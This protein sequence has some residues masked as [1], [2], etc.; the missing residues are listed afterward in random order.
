MVGAAVQSYELGGV[1][2][3]SRSARH[4]LVL[5]VVSSLIMGSWVASAQTLPPSVSPGRIPE[6]LQPPPTTRVAPQITIPETPVNLPPAGSETLRF[7][8]KS[9]RI[10]GSTVYSQQDLANLTGPLT[11]RQ[12]SVA[13]LFRLANAITTKYRADGYILSRA[14]VPAQRFN[15]ATNVVQ[16]IVVEGYISSYK[17]NGY[18]SSRIVDYIQRIMSSRPLKA[19]VLERY[20]LLTNDLP[21]VHATAVLSPVPNTTGGTLLTLEV[22]H[23]LFD[24]S[25]SSDNRG[26]RYVGPDQLYVGGDINIPYGEGR[27]AFRYVTVPPYPRELQYGEMSYTQPLGSDGLRL[28]V[29]GDG[30]GTHPQYGLQLFNTRSFGSSIGASLTYPIIRSR[31]TNLEVHGTFDVDTFAT[32]LFS[33]PYFPPSSDDNLRVLRAG[34]VYDLADAYGGTNLV[35]LEAAQGL[36]I[37]GASANG[38]QRPLPSRP[39][40]LS[41][42]TKLSGQISRVQDLQWIFPGL[43]V[44]VAGTMQVAHGPLPA[45]EQFGLGGPNYGRAY[46]PSDIVGDNGL[47]G[48]VELQYTSLP[49][50]GLR[51]LLNSYQ[52]YAFYDV[53]KAYDNIASIGSP[54]LASA[55]F[56]VRSKIYQYLSTDL[57]VA[58]GLTR[59]ES[60]LNGQPPSIGRPWRFFF[61][62]AINF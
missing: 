49:P 11:N 31:E 27:L 22:T 61:S 35:L 36:P 13:D 29:F 48:K 4:S 19:S 28:T 17:I 18:N 43:A 23:K 56:G 38:N 14:I 39:G 30:F 24:G 26:T 58:K 16:I 7:V 2:T 1:L 40:E 5:A 10:E 12:I 51:P 25:L 34:L 55:G 3:V 57:E 42:F 41:D 9:V 62:G 15:A 53:G 21:G 33:P 52:L 60:V 50:E 46:D 59:D 20:M 44:L 54:A 37:F 32:H 8:T 45:S 6:Q 47:A